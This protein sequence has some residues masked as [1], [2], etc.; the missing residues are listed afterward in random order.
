MLRKTIK[1]A[2]ELLFTRDTGIR[3]V[4]LNRPK[5]LNALN[6]NMIRELTAWL[7]RVEVNETANV[8][9]LKGA[10]TDKSHAL[11]SDF[12]A[13][14][15]LDFSYKSDVITKI[16]SGSKPL[17]PAF[18]AGGDIRYLYDNAKAGTPDALQ[19]NYE[20]FR[21]EYRLN[22]LLSEVETPVISFLNGLTLGGGAGLSVHGKFTV[23]TEVTSFAMPETA[24][25]FFPDVGASYFMSRLGR[26]SDPSLMASSEAALD[27]YLKFEAENNA[28]DS[29]EED[30]GPPAAMLQGIEAVQARKQVEGHN[31]LRDTLKKTYDVALEREY[32]AIET[33]KL[34]EGLGMYL[35][36]SGQK[37]KGMEV[38]AL[39]IAS[40]YLLRSDLV[41][42]ETELTG[43][44]HF[45]AKLLSQE[46]MDEMVCNTLS[47]IETQVPDGALNAEYHATMERI[48]GASVE[49]DTVS[50]MLTRLEHVG[51][52]WSLKVKATL[53]RMSPLSLLVT[54]RQLRLGASMD[55]KECLEMEFRIACRMM[56]NPDFIEGVRATL[57]EKTGAPT[58][59]HASVMDVTDAEVDRFFEPFADEAE[60]L[61]LYSNKRE[62]ESD[63]DSSDEEDEQRY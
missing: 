56:T 61:V 10:A 59:Q 2:S 50:G 42:L 4:E 52:E 27:A 39:G 54:H 21:E 35:A 11:A 25:G 31:K 14:E 29:D 51:S 43:L 7:H 19:L 53:E 17:P 20:F 38:V 34:G 33:Q 36:L 18:C 13:P 63:E 47:A 12:H 26:N 45:N 30:A 9:L 37:V 60:E 49:D 62:E 32:R 44:S 22:Y 5:V 23:A 57:V 1:N 28:Y 58:W 46:D 24:I 6:L 48:F 16:P 41:S 3:I 55:L 40:H 8:I 15:H